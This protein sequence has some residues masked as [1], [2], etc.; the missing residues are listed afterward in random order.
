MFF[1]QILICECG[2]TFHLQTYHL[3]NKKCYLK[4][5]KIFDKINTSL[6]KYLF[7]KIKKYK[8]KRNF[9]NQYYFGW[10]LL[11]LLD[12]LTASEKDS[13]VILYLAMTG[14]FS[15]SKPITFLES[16]ILFS[17]SISKLVI[18]VS[19]NSGSSSSLPYTGG[20]RSSGL[21]CQQ[22]P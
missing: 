9:G 21:F 1:Y 13:K 19:S 18:P 16:L 17:Y 22:S 2:S 15:N 8:N 7:K 14:T 10:F 5:Q 6:R 4:S 20:S 11:N 3:V 12:N